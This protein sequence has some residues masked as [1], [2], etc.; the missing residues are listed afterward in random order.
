MHNLDSLLR[1]LHGTTLAFKISLNKSLRSIIA[2]ISY[3]P[4]Q[5]SLFVK[6]ELGLIRYLLSIQWEFFVLREDTILF[7]VK[8]SSA[9]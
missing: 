9:S 2:V 8:T 5:K 3:L 1:F 7:S 4:I 6:H